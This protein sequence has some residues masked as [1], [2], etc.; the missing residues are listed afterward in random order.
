VLGNFIPDNLLP[1]QNRDYGF[2]EMNNEYKFKLGVIPKQTGTFAIGVDNA[3]NVFR[4]NDKCTKASFF[5]KFANTNQ[6]LYFIE[7]NRPGYTISESESTH[8]YCFKVK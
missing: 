4:T 7:Q 1:E 3:A 8:A 6:H 5:I 2:S